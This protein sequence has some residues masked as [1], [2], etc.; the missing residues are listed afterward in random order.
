[1]RIHKLLSVVDS[2]LLFS[3]FFLITPILH[4]ILSILTLFI[5]QVLL[6][7]LLKI[8]NNI[9]SCNIVSNSTQ[10]FS[11]S[12]EIKECLNNIVVKD[13]KGTPPLRPRL[14]KL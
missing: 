6:T 3:D 9:N 12:T 7:S 13:I 14:L 1:M 2:D 5:Y 11:I 4:P 8:I 10:S